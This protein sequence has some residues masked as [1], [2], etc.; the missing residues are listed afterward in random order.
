[1]PSRLEQLK[2]SF[3]RFGVRL[4]NALPDII[5]KTPSRD[6]FKKQIHETLIKIFKKENLYPPATIFDPC[7]KTCKNRV[8]PVTSANILT[9]LFNFA[10]S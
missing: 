2:N 3:S 9:V 6:F 4:W 10:I 1:M 5:K 7:R 8:I